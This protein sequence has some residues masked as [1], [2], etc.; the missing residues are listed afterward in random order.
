[1]HPIY[2]RGTFPN[3]IDKS[4]LDIRI[5]ASEICQNQYDIGHRGC[6]LMSPSYKLTMLESSRT[7]FH[8]VYTW[9]GVLSQ[10]TSVSSL[11]SC[12]R[13]CYLG[14]M[15]QFTHHISIS[16]LNMMCPLPVL[17]H[18]SLCLLSEQS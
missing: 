14:T 16:C 6:A 12:C 7:S 10:Y 1:M 8:L 2:F 17:A 3:K 5:Q 15:P 18:S 9:S 11:F 4:I 13:L